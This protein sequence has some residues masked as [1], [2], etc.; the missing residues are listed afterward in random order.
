MVP[1]KRRHVT[2]QATG[3]VSYLEWVQNRQ[4]YY[5][6]EERVNQQLKET[7]QTAWKD[8]LTTQLRF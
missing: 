3:N 2:R 4:R 8:V 6:K 5:W 7:L 1:R